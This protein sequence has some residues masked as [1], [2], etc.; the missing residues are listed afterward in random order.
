MKVTVIEI[1]TN[2]EVRF[3][4]NEDLTT[5]DFVGIGIDPE[6]ID[7]LLDRMMLM[8]VHE[9]NDYVTGWTVTIN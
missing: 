6:H 9:G 3:T 4:W 5:C 2:N 8:G 1:A 7:D